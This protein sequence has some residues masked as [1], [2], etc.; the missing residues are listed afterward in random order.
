[1]MRDFWL[2]GI[3][4]SSPQGG[5]PL[6]PALQPVGMMNRFQCILVPS[7]SSLLLHMLQTQASRRRMTQGPQCASTMV[8]APLPPSGSAWAGVGWGEGTCYSHF[9]DDDSEEAQRAQ[10]TGQRSSR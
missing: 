2:A 8:G 7:E 1:M 3:L 9:T 4:E 5:P 10:V 6:P